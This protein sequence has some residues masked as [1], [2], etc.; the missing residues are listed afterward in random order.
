MTKKLVMVE[1]LS[2][3]RMRYVFEVEDDIDHALDEY[4]MRYSETELKEFSQLHLE[5]TNIFSHREITKEEYLRIFDEDNDYLKSWEDGMKFEAGI[6]KLDYT[7]EPVG[8]WK[9]EI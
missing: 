6:N 2:Q 5:P 1:V 7:S 9:K 8:E 4:V 3:Y